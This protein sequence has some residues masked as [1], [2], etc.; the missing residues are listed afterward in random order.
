MPTFDSVQWDSGNGVGLASRMRG[1]SSA[2]ALSEHFE[3]PIQST[4]RSD[5][6]CP[7]DYTYSF[8]P[9]PHYDRAGLGG[10]ILDYREACEGRAGLGWEGAWGKLTGVGYFEPDE[11]P[12]ER[13]LDIAHEQLFYFRLQPSIAEAIAEMTAGWGK[14]TGLHIRRTDKTAQ[15]R[16]CGLTPSSDLE[17]WKAIEKD[18][19]DK[20]FLATDDP[21]VV[22]MMETQLAG[23]IIRWNHVFSRHQQQGQHELSFRWTGMTDAVLDLYTLAKCDHIIGT[24][25]SVFSRV[26]ARLGSIPLQLH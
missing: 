1:L 24:K 3:V 15:M 16:R 2:M 19:A 20:F 13:F 21:E 23:R 10:E 8:M 4:W 11:L 9:L 14:V 12:L 26:A 7:G 17:M 25:G 18:N 6:A 5:W 22:K